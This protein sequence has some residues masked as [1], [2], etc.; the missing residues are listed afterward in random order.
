[1]LNTVYHLHELYH[2]SSNI[3]RFSK[4]FTEKTFLKNAT[5]VGALFQWEKG[6]YIYINFN[7]VWARVRAMTQN[8]SGNN[9]TKGTAGEGGNTNSRAE[10]E[11]RWEDLWCGHFGERESE[12]V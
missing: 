8:K 5:K 6:E 9:K 2:T 3:Y 7:M 1:M 11:N 4:T 10:G 12:C